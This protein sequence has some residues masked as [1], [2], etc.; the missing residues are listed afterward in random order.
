MFYVA[1]KVGRRHPCCQHGDQSSHTHTA[2]IVMHSRCVFED[3][4]TCR[5]LNIVLN[6]ILQVNSSQILGSLICVFIVLCLFAV[7]KTSLITRFMYDSFDNTYQ[8]TPAVTVMPMWR[9]LVTSL[10]EI[11]PM[12]PV[13]LNVTPEVMFLQ[14]YEA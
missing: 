1:V 4:L 13:Y 6:M 2:E 7:G 14:N 9:F 11:C 3:G 5:I 10:G 8:V 12:L